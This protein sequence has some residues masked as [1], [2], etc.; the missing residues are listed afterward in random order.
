M[1]DYLLPTAG[2]IPPIEAIVLELSKGASGEDAPIAL[3]GAGERPRVRIRPF[4][5]VGCVAQRTPPRR[6][7]LANQ[8]WPRQKTT[9][10]SI[11]SVS[12]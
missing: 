7:H 3:K 5:F 6:G 11:S 12:P 8:V 10:C 4:R 1:I 9:L 2:E